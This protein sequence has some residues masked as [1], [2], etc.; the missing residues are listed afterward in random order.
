[1]RLDRR[2]ESPSLSLSQ[3]GIELE[4][5]GRRVHVDPVVEDSA[6]LA[7]ELFRRSS[8]KDSFEA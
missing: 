7:S 1:M 4:F 6:H 3:R 5:L 2:P 8:A